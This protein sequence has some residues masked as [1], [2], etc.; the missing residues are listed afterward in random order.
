M[1]LQLNL[2]KKLLIHIKA[3]SF[4]STHLTTP[5]ERDKVKGKGIA[6][7]SKASWLRREAPEALALSQLHPADAGTPQLI[8]FCILSSFCPCQSNIPTQ[9]PNVIFK[10]RHKVSASDCILHRI[11]SDY[12]GLHSTTQ[13]EPNN[14]QTQPNS[15]QQ[16]TQLRKR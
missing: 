2:P 9:H 1:N 4:N 14:I 13:Q 3:L 12:I 10:P 15:N 11:T 7:V 16:T 6:C 8:V 5:R